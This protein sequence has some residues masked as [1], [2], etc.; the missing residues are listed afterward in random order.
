M[1]FW[2]PRPKNLQ[3]T[4][5]GGFLVP[6]GGQRSKILKTELPG[7]VW[8]PRPKNCQ[9]ERPG[10]FL[11][12]FGSQDPKIEAQTFSEVFLM[13]IGGQDTKMIKMSL[14]GGGPDAI[15][16]PMPKNAQNG[17]SGGFLAPFGSQGSKTLKMSL[18]QG[19]GEGGSLCHLA[20]NA[21]KCSK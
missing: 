2:W 16:W 10:G 12:P 5:F 7:A 8:S 19:E 18:R 14:L 15:W 4:P 11:V 20:T 13:P 1:P 21:Q 9:N 17:P 3:N 6:F